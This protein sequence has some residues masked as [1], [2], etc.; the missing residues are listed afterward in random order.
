[1]MPHGVETP[2]AVRTGPSGAKQNGI[3]AN[4][5]P[6]KD[7]IPLPGS[8]GP[9]S[10]RGRAM[11]HQ[12]QTTAL[13]ERVATS[14]RDILKLRNVQATLSACRNAVARM[15]GFSDWRELKLNAGAGTPS[16]D[17]G[18]VPHETVLA[19]RLHHVAVLRDA[20]P[21]VAKDAADIV[22]EIGPTRQARPRQFFEHIS[23]FSFLMFETDEFVGAGASYRDWHSTRTNVLVVGKSDG[24]IGVVFGKVRIVDPVVLGEW[25]ESKGGRSLSEGGLGYGD[26]LELCLNILGFVPPGRNFTT[27]IRR[28]MRPHMAQAQE[29]ILKYVDREVF[30]AVVRAR[31]L[32]GASDY[33]FVREEGGN[34]ERRLSFLQT[35]PDVA[36]DRRFNRSTRFKMP[37]DA[38]RSPAEALAKLIVEHAGMTPKAAEIVVARIGANRWRQ[39]SCTK[40]PDDFAD[41]KVLADLPEELVPR[42]P[43]EIDAFLDVLFYV[44]HWFPS[45]VGKWKFVGAMAVSIPG[46]SWSERNATW[47]REGLETAKRLIAAGAMDPVGIGGDADTA[48]KFFGGSKPMMWRFAWRML[49]PL[50]GTTNWTARHVYATGRQRGNVGRDDQPLVPPLAFEAS[51]ARIFLEDI[52]YAG[53][54]DLLERWHPFGKVADRH[55]DIVSLQNDKHLL[56]ARLDEYRPFFREKYRDASPERIVEICL[57][58]MKAARTGIAGTWQIP[59]ITDRLYE[60]RYGM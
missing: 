56:P 13:A 38:A 22:E 16:L 1:M 49:L 40:T 33:A 47:H 46:R 53:L 2:K 23:D 59:P 44:G 37:I 3:S 15:H 21:A 30:E 27:A 42:D 58:D 31:M 52:D 11:R 34:R 48:L 19:R 35:Y 25:V 17:D 28:A 4:P 7:I 6:S 9:V 8:F 57:A 51:C 26:P 60:Q 39:E 24:R 43:K 14:L 36:M 50:I 5:S 29:A 55:A 18:D 41:L 10:I 54:K 12:T 32:V 20:F 45:R